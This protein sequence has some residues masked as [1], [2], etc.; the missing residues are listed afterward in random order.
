MKFTMKQRGFTMIE[1]MIVIAVIGILA[2]IAIPQYTQYVRRGWRAD[3]RAIMLDNAQ[4]MA[5]VYSQNLDYKP[6]GVTPTLPSIQAPAQGTKRYDVTVVP[7]A[8][9]SP[10]VSSYTLTATPSGWVDALCGNLTLTDKGVKGQSVAG[11]TT[12]NCWQR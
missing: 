5:R 12:D 7:V 6:G 11:A 4:F 8:A 9:A 3:A 10:T 2:A 1:L